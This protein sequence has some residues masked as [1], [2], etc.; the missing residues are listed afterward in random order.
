MHRLK[1]IVLAAAL[2]L[3]AGTAVSNEAQK[4][5][6]QSA[7]EFV[8]EWAKVL[9][10]TDAE[11]TIAFYDESEK[12]HLLGSSGQTFHGFTAISAAYRKDFQEVR[13][14][15]SHIQNL[16]MRILDGGETAVALFEHRFKFHEQNGS[17]Y[18]GH[19][20]TTQVL[21][22]TD[23]GWKIVHEHS[24]PKY[25]VDRMKRIAVND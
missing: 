20:R 13:I 4:S 11:K 9:N 22:R 6:E 19:V 21:H 16:S 14:S 15:D 7:K 10:E 24:S 1:N 8:Q 2:L 25:G 18:Q 12:T 3:I 23:D 5:P 17:V